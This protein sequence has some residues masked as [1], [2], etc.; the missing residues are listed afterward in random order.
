MRPYPDR[1]A[2]GRALADELGKVSG[3]VVVLGLARGGVPV[4]APIADALGAKLD[5][6]IVR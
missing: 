5:V 2:A 4:A 3:S 1:A 6:L